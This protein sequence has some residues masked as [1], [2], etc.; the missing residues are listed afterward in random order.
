MKDARMADA[1]VGFEYDA[2]CWVGRMVFEQE[3]HS[4][5]SST[6][7]VMLQ[8]ELRGLS[9]VGSS[10]LRT[11]RNAIPKYQNLP[12]DLPATSRFTTYE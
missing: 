2:G 9:R 5:T 8:I 11:L 10:P 7:R 4:L 1:I 6:K 12:P 3:Q